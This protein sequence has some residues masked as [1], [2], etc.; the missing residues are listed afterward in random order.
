MTTQEYIPM[1]RQ[2]VVSSTP[3]WGVGGFVAIN[4]LHQQKAV[5]QFSHGMKARIKSDREFTWLECTY[6]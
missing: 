5:L 4:Y 2:A 3:E 1:D 6:E